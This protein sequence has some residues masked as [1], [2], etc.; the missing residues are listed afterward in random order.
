MKC[1]LALTTVLTVT[2]FLTA[3]GVPTVVT[4]VH[5]DKVSATAGSFA[6]CPERQAGALSRRLDMFPATVFLAN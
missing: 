2:V 6:V 5:H 3:A 1:L 4:Y